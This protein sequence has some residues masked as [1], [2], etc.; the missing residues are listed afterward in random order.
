MRWDMLSLGPAARPP[1]CRNA[2]KISRCYLDRTIGPSGRGG[3][4]ASTRD[5]VVLASRDP[6]PMAQRVLDSASCR[7]VALSSERTGLGG[8]GRLI[9]M[10]LDGKQQ[11]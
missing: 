7:R 10:D 2:C 1:A 11:P 9:V 3:R 5:D 6:E 8:P 4:V